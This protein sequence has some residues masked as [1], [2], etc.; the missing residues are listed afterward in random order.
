MAAAWTG[1]AASLTTWLLASRIH[2]KRVAGVVRQKEF[3]LTG[4]DSPIANLMLCGK[5]RT[6]N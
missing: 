3:G 2:S 5:A 6:A 4:E 1:L